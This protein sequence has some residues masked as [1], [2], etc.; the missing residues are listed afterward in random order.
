MSIFHHQSI[1]FTAKDPLG[2]GL[3]DEIAEE[4]NEPEAIRSLDDTSSSDLEA[5]WGKVV[6]D[7]KK[8]KD[9]FAYADE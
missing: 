6:S 5:F 4:Q 3:G 9:F 2:N 1:Q 7:A 8:D